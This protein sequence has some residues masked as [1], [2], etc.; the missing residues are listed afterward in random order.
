MTQ[1]S[2]PKVHLSSSFRVK[3]L[4]I[5]TGIVVFFIVYLI[6]LIISIVFLLYSIYYTSMLL[7]SAFNL[8]TIIVFIG[9]NG[10]LLI[11]VFFL[12]K[13]FIP[14]GKASTT[15]RIE[16]EITEST[17]PKLFELINTVADEVK[18]IKPK[19][20]FLVPEVSASVHSETNLLSL[21]NPSNQ[22]LNIGLGLIQ[23][24]TEQELKAVLAHEFAH[25]SQKITW[26][27]V[28]I[29]RV[30]KLITDL[31]YSDNKWEQTVGESSEF[32]AIFG[33]FGEL[34]L[35]VTNV[36]KK[37]F[38]KV[39][40]IINIEFL[41]LSRDLE[42]H[43]DSIAVSITGTDALK[44]GLYKIEL[45]NV[46]YNRL[47]EHLDQY[48]DDG[49]L[50]KNVYPAYRW[51]MEYTALRN[52]VEM[53]EG[54]PIITPDFFENIILPRVNFK[55]QWASH[56]S[57]PERVSNIEKTG[58]SK[59]YDNTPALRLLSNKENIEEELTR[60]IYESSGIDLDKMH[61]IN[62]DEAIDK[63]S[64][65]QKAFETHESYNHFYFS[66]VLDIDI[67]ELVKKY[68]RKQIENTTFQSIYSKENR[69][70][71]DRLIQNVNDKYVLESIAT[72]RLKL[73]WFEFDNIKY[74]RKESSLLLTQ[75]TNEI[76]KQSKWLKDLDEKAFLFNYALAEK[77]GDGAT[78]KLQDIY[79]ININAS[80]LSSLVIG[81]SGH[82]QN[83][84]STIQNVMNHEG[85]S[86]YLRTINNDERKFKKEL[87]I[88]LHQDF[89]EH[90]EKEGDKNFAKN[91]IMDSSQHFTSQFSIDP[92]EFSSF[93]NFLQRLSKVSNDY[94][95]RTLRNLTDYQLELKN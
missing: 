31:L 62:A 36:L 28:F 85:A 40:N 20:V 50:L 30:N 72:K 3:T 26:V 7:E 48:F 76:E 19:K 86:D 12:G 44:N 52:E 25:F 38:L 77:K 69:K 24:M 68:D 42:F 13:I 41:S 8:L 5:A 55:D 43:A 6:S 27:S 39:Y 46:A 15:T 54:L 60:L 34:T 61:F 58:V 82:Y 90:L 18:T 94:Y 65:T 9:A 51:M 33:F 11:V 88:Y 22:N 56:P 14:S 92:I 95:L 66:R 81:Y 70:K 84:L 29:Y 45:A 47:S 10:F 16:F 1:N 89:M 17:Q 53:K 79:K 32:G 67:D 74:K 75:L 71:I 35:A 87:K 73:T 4:R 21:F 80:M 49:K 91:Y 59:K 37:I 63:I 23:V 2:F 93:Y 78:K 64:E 57:L 83:Q